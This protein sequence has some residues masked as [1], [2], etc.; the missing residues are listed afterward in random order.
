MEPFQDANANANY[1]E[2]P[3]DA[4]VEGIRFVPSSGVCLIVHFLLAGWFFLNQLFVMQRFNEMAEG[5]NYYLNYTAVTV[6]DIPYCLNV[7]ISK[8]SIGLD[9]SY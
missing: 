2:Y 6:N 9:K 8:H 5:I 1:D 7:L 3:E 4:I